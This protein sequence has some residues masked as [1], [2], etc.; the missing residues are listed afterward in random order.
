[1]RVDTQTILTI[2]D[3]VIT[4]N[5][6]VSVRYSVGTPVRSDADGSPPSPI[7]EITWQLTVRDVQIKDRGAYMCQL[8]SEPMASQIAY[9]HV[10]GNDR[11]RF[12]IVHVF[13]SLSSLRHSPAGYST[14][15]EQLGHVRS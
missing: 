2:D 9:L 7:G 12:V 8:N 13:L 6:R 1:M 10:N 5:P 4:K 11:R 15:P 14:R 3:V